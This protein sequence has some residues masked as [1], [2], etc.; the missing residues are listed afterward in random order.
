MEIQIKW[1]F[2]KK[3]HWLMLILTNTEKLTL[4]HLCVLDKTES[5]QMRRQEVLNTYALWDL[6][7]LFSSVWSDQVTLTCHNH[8]PYILE[9]SLETQAGSF[10]VCGVTKRTICFGRHCFWP[11][12]PTDLL[13]QVWNS[14]TGIFANECTVVMQNSVWTTLL[15]LHNTYSHY[16]HIVLL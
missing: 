5:G 6:P 11:A 2:R 10:T 3:R 8:V 16:L 12:I 1:K 15:P 4:A 9:I 14:H 7:E 13:L